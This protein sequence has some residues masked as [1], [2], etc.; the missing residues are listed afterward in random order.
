M[1]ASDFEPDLVPELLVT[2]VAESLEFWCGLCGFKILYDRPAEGFAYVTRGRA[3]VM[4][5]QRGVG[6]NW[7]TDEFE[8]PFGRGINF[9]IRVPDLAPILSA[10]ADASWSLFMQPETKWYR[11]SDGEEAGVRQFL[12]IDPDGYLIRFQ[13]SV[14]RRAVEE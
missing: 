14:G 8:R 6:R 11:V 7:L 12:V 13:S 2:D 5:E 3:H 1:V 10:L 9:Q 4:L